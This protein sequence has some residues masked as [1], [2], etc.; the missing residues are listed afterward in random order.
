M[1][2]QR[3]TCLCLC[4]TE[5]LWQLNE[6]FICSGLEGKSETDR[7]TERDSCTEQGWEVKFTVTQKLEGNMGKKDEEEEVWLVVSIVL[8]QPVIICFC[9]ADVNAPT[10]SFPV[11]VYSEYFFSIYQR[12]TEEAVCV[13]IKA[14]TDNYLKIILSIIWLIM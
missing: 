10:S 7:Q 11:H 1:V 9:D 14:A 4:L 6:G 3:V 12:W 8:N 2:T 13:A 5:S